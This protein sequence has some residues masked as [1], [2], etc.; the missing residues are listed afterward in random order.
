MKPRLIIAALASLLLWPPAS[1]ALA[2][3]PCQPEPVVAPITAAPQDDR[4]SSLPQPFQTVPSSFERPRLLADAQQQAASALKAA[5]AP[6]C[7]SSRLPSVASR[8]AFL[9]AFEFL[10][11][12]Y[13]DHE[14]TTRD[15]LLQLYREDPQ[16]AIR[17]LSPIWPSGRAEML[18]KTPAFFDVD[19]NQVYVNL[20]ALR[21]D[22]APNVLIH[23]FWHALA[24]V[25]VSHQ[26]D[27][28]ISRTTG[29]WTEVR[30]AGGRVWR[31][32]DEQLEGGVPTYLM[33]EAMAIE[34]EVAATGQQHP[35]MHPGLVEAVH[36][37][38]DLFEVAGRSR[39]LQLY[40]ESRSDELKL[41]ARQAAT[42]AGG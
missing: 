19:M 42:L 12:G 37:L 27:G 18:L 22:Q 33:N 9:S 38:H 31:P 29:F 34:M 41:I 39:V 3:A 10:V 2:E 7:Y 5:G 14:W 13:Y 17:R 8:T 11:V 4:T 35:N 24:D 32:V 23:E 25:R 1:A 20:S 16:Q 40:L 36:T 28:A 21:P 30:P 15:A 6:S 26:P